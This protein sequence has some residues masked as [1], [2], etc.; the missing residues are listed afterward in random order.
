MHDTEVFGL[1]VA[2]VAL[3]LLLAVLSN[4]VSERVRV[5]APA[6]FLVGAAVLSDLFPNLGRLST[7][8][9]QHAVTVALVLILFN[10]GVD[11]GWPTFRRNAVAIV[12]LGVAGTLVTAAALAV[13][14]HQIFGF[15]WL[16]SLLLATALSPTDPAVV[17]AVLGR[18][19]VTGR[20]GTLLEGESGANDP[21]GIALLLVLLS[22]GSDAG[23]GTVAG[24]LAAFALQLGLGAAAGWLGG[25]ALLVLMR[26]VGLPSEGL[27]PLAVLAGVGLI[28]GA[29]TAVG[30]SG[31]LAV[32]VAGVVVGDARA[33]YKR[34][35][36]RFHASLASLGEIVAFALLGLSVQLHTLADPKV[37]LV[38]LALAMALAL[39]VRPV[40][41][42]LVIAPLDLRRNERVFIL[43][44]GLKGAVPILL[45]SFIL[46]SDQPE[47][48]RLFGIVVVV[49]AI[50][51]VVQGGLVP[52]VADRVGLPVRT[53]Q[54]E[55]WAL[56]MRLQHE[57]HG[58][59]EYDIAVGSPADGSTIAGLPVG[60]EAWIS[61][62]SRDGELLQVRGDTVL[63]A[64]DRVLVLVETGHGADVDRVFRAPDGG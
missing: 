43:W 21:V 25:K 63:G 42:G 62:V 60:E 26:R 54:P 16:P 53:V 1:V 61:I 19:E 28:F 32:F 11:I 15:D 22:A 33:P 57:P 18:R 9:V 59:R 4:R 46:T 38:G 23:L 5:P 39:V 52:T 7:V 45:G 3:G 30:G 55:P 35:I 50:S 64:G 10:G 34:E 48:P 17:F 12:W 31:F 51:V 44:A 36:E 37:W 27:Y 49:V 56:G 14:A 47:A 24:G 41:V 8:A 40:L 29:T 58:L 20:A 2:A 6:F 13:L